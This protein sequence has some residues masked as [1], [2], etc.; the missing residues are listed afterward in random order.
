MIQPCVKPQ[1]FDHF[2]KL[3]TS[4]ETIQDESCMQ[5]KPNKAKESQTKP[6]QAKCEAK[7][8]MQTAPTQASQPKQAKESQHQ[9]KQDIQA[10]LFQVRLHQ[11]V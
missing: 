8:A 5:A 7:Q 2:S 11:T 10:K 9:N 3:D 6:S 4:F 1:L